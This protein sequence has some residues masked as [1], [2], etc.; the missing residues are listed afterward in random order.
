MNSHLKGDCRF[1]GEYGARLNI[2]SNAVSPR[3][4]R[5]IM[6]NKK[7]YFLPRRDKLLNN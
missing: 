2:L 7:L 4:R 1:G 5:D 3:A 6:A